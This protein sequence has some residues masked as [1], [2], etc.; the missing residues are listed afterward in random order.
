MSANRFPSES[1]LQLMRL[2]AELCVTRDK[3]VA[4]ALG[5]SPVALSARIK[6]DSFPKDKLFALA[7]KSPELGIDV[8]FV[9]AGL[10]ATRTVALGGI[11]ESE[12]EHR[13]DLLYALE[14]LV[15]AMSDGFDIWTKGGE[16]ICASGAVAE[17]LQ[18]VLRVAIA[19]ELG[20]LAGKAGQ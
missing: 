2:K 8:D 1:V 19:K 16:L 3:E 11:H 14:R 4:A 17:S 10:T 5:M 12:F 7:Q 20:E 13:E 15:P 18:N 6:R 9:L